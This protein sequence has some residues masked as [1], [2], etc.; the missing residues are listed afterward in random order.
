M[1]P[2]KSTGP[3]VLTSGL[4]SV[5]NLVR[6]NEQNVHYVVYPESHEGIIHSFIDR[7]SFD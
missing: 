2:K 1:N 3:K 4:K 7:Y 5:D 6:Y